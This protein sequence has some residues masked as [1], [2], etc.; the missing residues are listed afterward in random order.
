M[1]KMIPFPT[2]FHLSQTW[3]LC[4]HLLFLGM[5]VS[6][7]ALYNG[8]PSS[9]MMPEEGLFLFK[10]S[11]F[12]LKVGY[13]WDDL[14][15]RR[16]TLKS[17]NPGIDRKVQ[18]YAAMSHLGVITLGFNDRVEIYGALGGIDA[19]IH[20]DPKEKVHLKCH[21][22]MQFAW[23]IGGKVILA[24]WGNVQLGIDAK[25]LQ[26]N[27][28]I[29]RISVNQVPQ[30]PKKANYHYREWQLGLSAS[31]RQSWWMPYLGINYADV[32]V[33]CRQFQAVA[34]WMNTQKWAFKNRFPMG[35][36]LG[37]GFSLSKGFVMNAELRLVTEM[38][39]TLSGDFR[40]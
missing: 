28:D 7:Q 8:N 1:R 27:P 25:Y 6:I 33:Q 13:E 30:D 20:Y 39:L 29:D 17:R 40:F 21:I 4:G 31:Y 15:N 36:F 38:A 14:F 10:D 11:W 22:D 34:S 9:P 37:C 12:A 16:L 2:C 26:F 3:I 23:D 19:D 24:Y 5:T 18:T 35:C 32:R